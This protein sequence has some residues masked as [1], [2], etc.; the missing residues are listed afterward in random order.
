MFYNYAYITDE[1]IVLV[2][3]FVETTETIGYEIQRKN[4]FYF[5]YE[6]YI[7][8]MLPISIIIQTLR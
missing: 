6:E 1:Y 5:S 8:Y 7:M 3:L 4:P 2:L